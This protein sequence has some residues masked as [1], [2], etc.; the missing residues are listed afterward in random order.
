[1]S[2]PKA[3]IAVLVDAKVKELQ[4]QAQEQ[5]DC[6]NRINA[7]FKQLRAEKKAAIA[8]INT[9]SGAIQAYQT[10]QDPLKDASAPEVSSEAVAEPVEV[11]EGELI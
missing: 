4:K 10:L 2:L 7:A 11:L 3:E 9:L 8:N 5:N 1:M 6:L